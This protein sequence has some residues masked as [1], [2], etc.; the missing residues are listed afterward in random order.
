MSMNLNSKNISAPSASPREPIPIMSLNGSIL[1]DAALATPMA[2]LTRSLL[3]V[4]VARPFM[5]LQM[6]RPGSI[7]RKEDV[8][9]TKNYLD[10]VEP[11]GD[12]LHR[13]Y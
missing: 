5:G 2:T 6:M 1:E 11:D 9:T 12:Y 4:D 10:G 13:A 8:S 3:R 7:I